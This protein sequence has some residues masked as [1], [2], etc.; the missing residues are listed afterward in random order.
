MTDLSRRDFSKRT[1]LLSCLSVLALPGTAAAAAGAGAG[2]LDK[3]KNDEFLKRDDIGY[4]IKSL[5][6][7]Y[8][9]TTPYPHKFNEVLTKWQMRSLQFFID[10]GLEKEQVAHYIET[11][12][13]LLQRIKQQVEKE[14][15]EKALY[16]MFEGTS[17]GYQLFERIN[18]K[19][20]KRFFPCPYKGLLV[21][22]KKYLGTF[23]IEWQDI[24]N[25]WCMPVWNGFADRIGVEIAIKPGKRCSVKLVQP[26]TKK[27]EG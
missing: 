3:V 17:C 18:V 24:C 1:M 16:G 12:D 4:A 19:K 26:E 14:G 23:K 21:E 2:F 10:K 6:Q 25:K 22:C 20:G 7:S 9:C 5:Y 13:P 15:S 8:N 11:M 27:S